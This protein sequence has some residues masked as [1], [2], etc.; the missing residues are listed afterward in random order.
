MAMC[1]NT[2][3][4]QTITIAHKLAQLSTSNAVFQ[5]ERI[6]VW[7]Q[8]HCIRVVEQ[9]HGAKPGNNYFSTQNKNLEP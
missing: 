6:G 5:L 2:Q 9:N 4:L 3:Q 1:C 7:Q 8:A